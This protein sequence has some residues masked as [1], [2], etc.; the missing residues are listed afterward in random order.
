MDVLI[1]LSNSIISKKIT[2][3]TIQTILYG[4]RG[5]NM[6]EF[7]KQYGGAVITVIAIIAL[8]A[9]ITAVIHSDA[10][11]GTFQNLITDFYT[12]ASSNA[13]GH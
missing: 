7:M 5:Q 13:G 2:K 12:K 11:S 8:I 10:T 3:Q 4:E 1:F 6:E 9:V